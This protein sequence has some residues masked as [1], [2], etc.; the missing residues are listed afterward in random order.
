IKLTGTAAGRD[1]W[2]LLDAGAVKALD[3]VDGGLPSTYLCSRDELLILAD[4]LL[5]HAAAAEV[6]WIVMEIADGLLQKETAALFQCPSFTSKIN[7]WLFATRDP[8]GAVGGVSL[9]RHWGIEPVVISGL[10]SQS[11]LAIFEVEG[12]TGIRC[13]TAK[14]LRRGKLNK[15]LIPG[16]NV[17]A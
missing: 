12:A 17:L 2:N 1:T 8:L 7:V 6:D 16:E 15:Q 4:L 9:L 3:F 14:E 11:P 10:V 5:G 13:L